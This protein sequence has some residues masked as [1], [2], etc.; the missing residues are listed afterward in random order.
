MAVLPSTYESGERYPTLKVEEL[1]GCFELR[2]RVRGYGPEEV[3]AAFAVGLTKLTS[4]G[5][6]A[7]RAEAVVK[8]GLLTLRVPRK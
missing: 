2:G 1:P 5:I 8:D 4:M 3:E 7:E 6:N